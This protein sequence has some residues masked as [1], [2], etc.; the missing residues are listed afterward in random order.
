[1]TLIRT[2]GLRV[3]YVISG[4][5][6][7]GAEMMLYKL[8]KATEFAVTSK[9][10]V[11]KGRGA[12]TEKFNAL[13]IEIEYLGLDRATFPRP[14]VIRRILY[15]CRQF[16]PNVVQGWMYHGNCV[17]WLIKLLV[18]RQSKLIWNIRQTLYDL[19]HEKWMTRYVI[20]LSRWLSSS[21]EKIIY[22]SELSAR[23]HEAVGYPC[24][25]S[26]QIPNGFDLNRFKPDS[27]ARGSI[28]E[29]F[30]LNPGA[31]LIVHVARYHPM[32]DHRTM[33]RAIKIISESLPDVRFLFVGNGV[34]DENKD[35]LSFVDDL[36]VVNSLILAGERSDLPRLM[37]A[38]DL[39][40]VS[41]A[42][43]EGFPNVIGEAM[44]CGT[45]CVVTDIGSSSLIVGKT[46]KVVPP[47][48]PAALASAITELL[49]DD[50]LLKGCGVAARARV[51]D[52][53]S[54]D[55]ISQTYLDLYRGISS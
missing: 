40:V 17:A 34:T 48:N 25:S 24:R 23:Q 10:L 51:R 55:K 32:K 5:D 18:C 30:S 1:M 27:R 50:V 43:G 21:A 36:E 9:I 22:N 12:L 38:A 26:V 6:T 44:A 45:P 52:A 4:L 35:L 19:D 3:L 2:A 8:V 37:A 16:E 41:S 14:Q 47:R 29:E 53:Y 31:P 28:E 15:M 7:G 42:W 54:I 46:G 11:V 33:L 39:I 13:G 20:R 49:L